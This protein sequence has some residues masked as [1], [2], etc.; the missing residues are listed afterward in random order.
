MEGWRQFYAGHGVDEMR[1]LSEVIRATVWDALTE[2]GDENPDDTLAHLTTPRHANQGDLALPCFALAKVMQ[3]SPQD[4]AADLA[5][6]V[7]TVLTAIDGCSEV[8]S[9]GGFCNF[10][11]DVEWLA[12]Q[13]MADIFNHPE[14]V[15]HF[16]PPSSLLIEHT[17]ANPNGPFHV[18]RS[19]NAI[20]GDTFVRM[21][22]LAGDD[23]R[24]EYYV[25][26]MGKQVG[27]LAW[28]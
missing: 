9:D 14:S 11:V 6:R 4:I 17:S 21:H 7:A 10:Y 8:G 12:N 26:D 24:A 1:Q 19:R 13:I 28:A 23:V 22:R 18:G 2:M 16:R 15:G 20:L 25:D 5:Q 27:I 3:K